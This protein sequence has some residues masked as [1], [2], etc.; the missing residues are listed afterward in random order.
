[1]TSSTKFFLS[2]RQ[3]KADGRT[4]EILVLTL[5]SLTTHGQATLNFHLPWRIGYQL[6]LEKQ[7][8]DKFSQGN[9]GV[10]FVSTSSQRAN[11]ELDESSTYL[12]L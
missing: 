5:P 1:M 2:A 10:G 4:S 7:T 8:K 11:T 9:V 12:A 6:R 3:E